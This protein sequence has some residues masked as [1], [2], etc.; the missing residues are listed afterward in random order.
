MS[1]FSTEIRQRVHDARLSVSEALASGDE[2]LAQVLQSELDGL[3]RLAAEH[4]VA[5]D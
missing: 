5:V 4:Q 3:R 1:D 2:Y